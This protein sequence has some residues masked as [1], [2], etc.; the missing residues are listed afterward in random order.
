MN[1]GNL[2]KRPFPQ[3]RKNKRTL[4]RQQP[5]TKWLREIEA[6]FLDIRQREA[7]EHS[8]ILAD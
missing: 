1:I 8:G 6:I 2:G 7:A 3:N 4:T 5:K